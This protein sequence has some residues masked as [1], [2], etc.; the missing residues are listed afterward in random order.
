MTNN[1]VKLT[2]ALAFTATPAV[3]KSHHHHAHG[4][5]RHHF[6][7]ELPADD[8]TCLANTAYR[9]ARN[10]DYNLQAVA[11]V[12]KNRVR[13]GWGQNYCQVVRDG[14][15]V[16]WVR[17]PNQEEYARAY[18]I[19]KKVME[20]AL[21][22]NTGGAVYFHANYLRHLPRWANRHYLTAKIGGN[23]FYRDRSSE[24]RLA[25]SGND[26]LINNQD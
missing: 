2:L 14:R 21:P 3:A 1:L 15:F 18:D 17:H 24:V 4:H 23:V 12:A 26:D 19:A 20:D 11:N 6:Q 9:E 16:Y 5:H 7:A 8:L 10:S 25:S 13:F 22:D